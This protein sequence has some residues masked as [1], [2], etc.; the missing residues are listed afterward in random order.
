[1]PLETSINN[2]KTNEYQIHEL[3]IDILSQQQL[4]KRT[5]DLEKPK[6]KIPL[7][8]LNLSLNSNL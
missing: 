2:L 4:L 5:S 3:N 1:M 8:K 6:I 7:L